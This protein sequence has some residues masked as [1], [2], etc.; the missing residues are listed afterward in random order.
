MISGPS[1]ERGA[2]E[3]W[4]ALASFPD[5]KSSIQ[6]CLILPTKKHRFAFSLI[7][8]DR[9]FVYGQIHPLRENKC[10]NLDKTFLDKNDPK[11]K[12]TPEIECTLKP[13]NYDAKP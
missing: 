12:L 10:G 1:S 2:G 3:L 7:Y 8:G 13:S 4:L 11:S 9:Y 6:T 5:Q